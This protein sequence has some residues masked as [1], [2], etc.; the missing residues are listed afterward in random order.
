[1]HNAGAQAAEESASMR[2]GCNAV[3]HLKEMGIGS[4][5]NRFPLFS[6]QTSSFLFARCIPL[7]MEAESLLGGAGS[8]ASMEQ[9]V[10]I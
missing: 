1:L 7:A 6:S 4:H 9:V 5:L 2:A 3:V 10:Y 8:S